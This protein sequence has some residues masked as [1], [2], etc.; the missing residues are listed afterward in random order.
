MRY[1][2]CSDIHLGHKRTPTSHIINS[3]KTSILTQKN[4]DIDLLFI[5]GDLFDKLLDLNSKE[6]REIIGFFNHLLDYCTTNSIKLRVLYGTP[7]H[8]HNQSEILVKL[9]DIRTTPADL[10][11]FNI[12]DIEYLPEYD[13]YVLYIPD[14]WSHSHQDIENQITDKLNI[15]GITQVDIAILHGQFTYQVKGAFPGLFYNENYFLSLVKGFIHIGHYHSHSYFDRIIANGSLER[16]AHNEEEP[17]G[18]VIVHNKT[19][20]FVH[21]HNAYIYK[22]IKVTPTTTLEKLDK[23]IRKY[24]VNSYI[25]LQVADDHPFAITFQE[26]RVRYMDYHLKRKRNKSAEEKTTVAYILTDEQLDMSNRF[27]I[28][29]D[30][31]KTVLSNIDAKHDLSLPE[32]SKLSKYL[33]IFSDIQSHPVA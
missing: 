6:V 17:K 9:N 2:V 21:N 14:E 8:D 12:L 10:R 28:D 16:L 24:P 13:K 27:I 18:Y 26:L 7:S 4:A 1:V 33:E 23:Q 5:A 25:Q 30:V 29:A 31:A 22:T 11:Y 20:S 32:L 19:Y 3:F 15:L